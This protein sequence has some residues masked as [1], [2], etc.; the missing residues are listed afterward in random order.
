MPFTRIGERMKTLLIALLTLTACGERLRLVDT[1]LLPLV[2]EYEAE[3]GTIKRVLEMNFSELGEHHTA[4][5]H[6]GRGL[7]QITVD[8]SWYEHLSSEYQKELIFKVLTGC[9]Q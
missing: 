2:A 4:E 3:N 1:E 7:V 5:C 6:F 9:T 8:K